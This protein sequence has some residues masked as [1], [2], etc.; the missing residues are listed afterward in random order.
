[1]QVQLVCTIAN[2]PRSKERLMVVY[3]SAGCVASRYTPIVANSD[4]RPKVLEEYGVERIS[5]ADLGMCT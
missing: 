2:T 5:E 1:M 3:P 4:Y